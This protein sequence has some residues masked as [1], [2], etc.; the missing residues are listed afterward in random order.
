VAQSLHSI[1]Q[2]YAAWSSGDRK[3]GSSSGSLLEAAGL[4]SAEADGRTQDAVPADWQEC[5]ADGVP[6]ADGQHAGRS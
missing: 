5:N 6:V 4:D 1:F 3:R 2:D